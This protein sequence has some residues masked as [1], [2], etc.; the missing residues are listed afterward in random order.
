MLLSEKVLYDAFP[1]MAQKH[2]ALQEILNCQTA[3]LG[4]AGPVANHLDE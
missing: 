1:V 4:G 3:T 2:N